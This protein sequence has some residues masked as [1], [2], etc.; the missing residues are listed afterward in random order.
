MRRFGLLI[1]TALILFPLLFLM[2][3]TRG[4]N[5]FNKALNQTYELI[6]PPD[7]SATSPEIT[8]TEWSSTA[9]WTIHTDQ[10]WKVYRVWLLKQIGGTY[11]ILSETEFQLELR[12]TF[13]AEIHDIKLI[14]DEVEGKI[15]V[16]YS[17]SLW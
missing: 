11:R 12:Q 1:F 3:S 9:E 17:V 16:V 5:G 7:A 8:R 15:H 13:H 10:T 2:T 6:L 14:A 4:Q